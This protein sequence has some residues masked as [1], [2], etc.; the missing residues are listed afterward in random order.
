MGD[1]DVL[2]GRFEAAR[3]R[4]HAVAFR[5]LGSHAAAD[6]AVQE[7]WLRLHRSEPGRHRQPR[8]LAD[9]RGVA[10]LPR[11]PQVRFRTA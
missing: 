1:D 6:D 4:L 11:H 7:A 3:P 10:D 9:H 8:R 2:A 5:M